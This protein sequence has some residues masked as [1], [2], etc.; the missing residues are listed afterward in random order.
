MK[1][2]LLMGLVSFALGCG[3]D[4]DGASL[5]ASLCEKDCQ[6]GTVTKCCDEDDVCVTVP[7]D[8]CHDSC[9]ERYT[10]D[11]Q[12]C[13]AQVDDYAKCATSTEWS[14]NEY[15]SLSAEA[16]NAEFLKLFCCLNPNSSVCP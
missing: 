14:C 1:R 2:W 10:N 8:T 13:Q 6:A 5:I 4:D 9:I 15:G 3:S 7:Y 11:R 16:C 12:H